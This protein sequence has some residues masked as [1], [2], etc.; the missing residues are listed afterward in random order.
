[1]PKVSVVMSVY[2]SEQYLRKAVESIITQTFNDWEFIIVNDGST[3]NTCKI[4]EEFTDTRIRVL[5]QI[6]TG[7]PKALNN[8]ILNSR[9]EFIARMD[10][11]DIALPT[12]LETQVKFLE[13]H[14]D[15]GIVGSGVYVISSSGKIKGILNYPLNDKEIRKN[16]IKR[17]CFIHPSVMIRKKVFEEVG[18]YNPLFTN[19]ED[20]ELWFRIAEHYKLANIEEPLLMYRVF[21]RNITTQ[22]QRRMLLE[23]IYL[24]FRAIKKGLYPPSSIIHLIGPIILLGLPRKIRSNIRRIGNIQTF[25]RYKK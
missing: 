6:N 10:A 25:K 7:L 13:Q 22:R 21:D 20:Y 2:N 15:I 17:N 16:L 14:P 18:Y 9:G 5:N 11:D 12:R 24:R 4:L 19:S 8:G 3:D 1:M 23:G